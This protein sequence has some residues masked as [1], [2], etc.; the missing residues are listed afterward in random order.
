MNLNAP[1][2]FYKYEWSTGLVSSSI[3]IISS[4]IYILEVTD[5]NSCTA[6]DSIKIEEMPSPV[7][8]FSANN[9]CEGDEVNFINSSSSGNYSWR[10][11]DGNNLSD[12]NPVYT[13]AQVGT[14]DV[15][16][17]VE[18]NGCVDSLQSSVI[19][20]AKPKIDFETNIISGCMPLDVEFSN[21][22]TNGK[23]FKWDFGDGNFSINPTPNHTYKD[24]G[25]YSISL[26]A[27]SKEG[28]T[29]DL[30]RDSSIRI[31]P[32]PVADF[33]MDKNELTLTSSEVNF[34]NNSTGASSFCWHFSD[35]TVLIN[36]SPSHT[37]NDTGLF[38]VKQ[39]ASNQYGCV[40]SLEK[41]V[42]ILRDYVF[43]MPTAFTPNNDGLN[44]VLMPKGIGLKLYNYSFSIYN[45]WGELIYA[46]NTPKDGWNGKIKDK[47][48]LADD[49]AYAWKIF[50]TDE[51]FNLTKSYS[52]IISLMK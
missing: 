18:K 23:K 31:Y 27:I 11:G 44:D 2:G 45:R 9:V 20:Y 41:P 1:T 17:V 29:S 25:L 12:N 51:Q 15:V 6:I 19:V 49:G 13:Y 16:L 32:M 26:T 34:I 39:T 21:A 42:N 33:E 52:G 40:D 35:G 36:N 22:T 10:L 38:M 24:S 37:F 14:Y 8:S 48:I 3:Q 46:T 4:G 5:S 30:K 7:V 47:N 43:F 50:I 28:C